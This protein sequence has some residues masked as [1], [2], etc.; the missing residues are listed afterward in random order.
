MG[1]LES[2]AR[3]ET[4]VCL[5]L[6]DPLVQR[7]RLECPEALALSAPLV[8]LVCLVHKVSR[9]LKVPLEDLVQKERRVFRDLLDL[10]AHQGK[11]SSLCQSREAPNPSVPS[12]PVRLCQS[13]TRT[14]LLLMPPVQSSSLAVKAW[15]RSLAL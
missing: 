13:Q 4:V 6:T 9:E 1:L 8:P 7:E 15:R 5:G 12:M 10:L 11:S 2:R 14:C 3:R